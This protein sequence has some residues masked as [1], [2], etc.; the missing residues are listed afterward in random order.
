MVCECECLRGPG[1]LTDRV[2][3]PVDTS[4]RLPVPTVGDDSVSAETMRSF[5]ELVIS[6]NIPAWRY[7]IL[8]P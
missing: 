8:Y 2:S 4:G 7:A 1:P 3:R 6:V 5:S